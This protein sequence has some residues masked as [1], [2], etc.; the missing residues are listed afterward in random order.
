[1]DPIDLFELSGYVIDTYGNP[2]E[3]VFFASNNTYVVQRATAVDR[4]F[5]P[6]TRAYV[7]DGR[8]GGSGVVTNVTNAYLISQE[9]MT[10]A[11]TTATSAARSR[12][13]GTAVLHA[14]SYEITL[15]ENSYGM[16]GNGAIRYKSAGLANMHNTMYTI[17]KP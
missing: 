14:T 16:H 15:A 10:G 9:P 2:D 6:A 17:E 13:L 11:T 4:I 7:I 5:T 8:T 3:W 1:M 12:L